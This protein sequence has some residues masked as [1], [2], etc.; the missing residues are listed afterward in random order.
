MVQLCACLF[1]LIAYA[2]S[3]EIHSAFNVAA[4]AAPTDEGTIPPELLFQT[5]I[6]KRGPLIRAY[7]VVIFAA[8][9]SFFD[10]Q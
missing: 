6:I 3:K 8:V 4:D 9:C 2:L 7:S 5:V 10:Y 1:F